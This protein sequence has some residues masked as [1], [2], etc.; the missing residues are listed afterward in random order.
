MRS[1]QDYEL[2]NIK[3]KI[4]QTHDLSDKELAVKIAGKI[5]C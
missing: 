5:V 4:S 3:H 2:S 1:W